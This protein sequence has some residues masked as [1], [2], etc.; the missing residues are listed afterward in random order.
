MVQDKKAISLLQDFIREKLGGDIHKLRT[1]DFSA[2]NDD[3]KY[4]ATN[5]EDAPIVKAVMSVAFGDVWPE[6]SMEKIDCG[7]YKCAPI[8]TYQNL[9]GM[10]M[11]D[12]YFKGM[13]K[14]EPSSSQ[15][16]RALKVAHMTYSLGN[17]WVLPGNGTIS[18]RILDNCYRY[19]MDKFL[20]SIYVVLT[21]Q[22]SV[23]KV[24]Q[25]SID[26]C[27][28]MEPYYGE[29]GFHK[30]I[31]DMMLEDYVDYYYKPMDIFEFVWSSQKDLDRYKY[32]KAV[33]EYCSFCEKAFVKRADKI[34]EKLEAALAAK[35]NLQKP[36]R[37][38]VTLQRPKPNQK[39]TD[40][41]SNE[42]YIGRYGLAY[43][44]MNM[45]IES[46][47]ENI[48]ER[49]PAMADKDYFIEICKRMDLK[50]DGF[51]W[52]EFTVSV[53]SYEDILVFFY[54]FPKPQREPQAKYGA[55]LI[56]QNN[57]KLE[58]Y[59]LEMCN[60]PETW[61]LGLNTSS[62]HSLMGMYDMEPTKENF[63][64]L[65]IPKEKLMPEI[66][67]KSLLNLPMEYKVIDNLP[68]DPMYSVNYGKNTSD[69]T[70]II[71]SF[72][73]SARRTM[74]YYN[75]NKIIYGIHQ[76]LGEN[77]ALIE[78]NAGKTSH[79]RQYVYSI[80]KTLDRPSR[81]Q[82]FMLIH[83]SYEEIAININGFFVESG[84]TGTRDTMIWELACRQ[85]IVSFEDKSKWMFDPY[86]KSFNRPYMMNISEK[87]EYDEMF[88]DHPLSQ[89]RKFVKLIT[90]R[91]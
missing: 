81:V 69:C 60:E 75:V 67:I 13:Q 38:I 53:E 91:L 28:Q 2:L 44:L 31:N 88:P 61:A 5:N 49:L 52:D 15:F 37:P 85:G 78:V 40:N 7:P 22:K 32:F 59:T 82:Y 56:Y 62:T 30:F 54:G 25:K 42:K 68:E 39:Q 18:N 58:Y 23:D 55:I 80:V 26:N 33:D 27:P 50:L 46:V 12:Q 45:C 90:E 36:E 21:K 11:C 83:V 77:Q 1:F 34:I 43:N 73:M 10:N 72:P 24:L 87:E 79:N 51:T 47:K 41:D 71:H 66:D 64:K 57:K 20:K 14:F 19:Y 48:E 3:R 74:D 16:Q 17:L 70:S 84:I 4:G 8:Q 29:E 63:L 89:C 6:L 76:S 35:P 9:F 65:I 86:D